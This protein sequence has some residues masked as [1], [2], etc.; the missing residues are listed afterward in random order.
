MKRSRSAFLGLFGLVAGVQ[1]AR[2]GCDPVPPGG[3]TTTPTEQ[4]AIAMPRPGETCADAVAGNGGVWTLE[5]VGAGEQGGAR[6]GRTLDRLCV[7]RWSE[8]KK[9]NPPDIE[10]FPDDRYE[11]ASLERAVVRPLGDA[12]PGLRGIVEK[13]RADLVAQTEAQGTT[14]APPA[15]TVVIGFPDTSREPRAGE[16]ADFIPLGSGPS[17]TPFQGNAHGF[18]LA[19]M[20]RH[21]TCPEGSRGPC[22][23]TPRMSFALPGGTASTRRAFALGI[24]KLVG[25]WVRNEK[26]RGQ[27]LILNLAAGWEPAYECTLRDKPLARRT[28]DMANGQGPSP[29]HGNSDLGPSRTQSWPPEPVPFAAMTSECGGA[30]MVLSIE[31]RAV[32]EELQFA[33]CHGALIVAAAGNDPLVTPERKGPMLPAAWETHG[34]PD[35]ATCARVGAPE[36]AASS[37]D[38]QPLVYAASGVY[39]NDL[40]VV[41][42]RTG[43]TARIVAPASL[44]AAY[45]ADR[46]AAKYRSACATSAGNLCDHT[47]PMTGSSVAATVVSSAAAVL[48]AYNPTWD[49]HRVMDKVHEVGE[50]LGAPSFRLESSGAPDANVAARVSIC[51]AM[52]AALPEKASICAPR[53][54][55]R[56]TTPPSGPYASIAGVFPFDETASLGEVDPQP[57]WPCPACRGYLN[58]GTTAGNWAIT[59]EIPTDAYGALGADLFQVDD[60]PGPTNYPE[61]QVQ[62]TDAGGTSLLV[63][64]AGF[65][66]S[67]TPSPAPGADATWSPTSSRTVN[68][69]FSTPSRTPVAHILVMFQKKRTGGTWLSA[70]QEIPIVTGP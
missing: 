35:A 14:F 30:P 26:G 8:A 52:S 1:Q 13:A 61:R 56:G 68:G 15:K 19:W 59:G 7:Y 11:D 65:T 70:A 2:C 32:L 37:A 60:G 6:A 16:P 42:T 28:A 20:G 43:G 57:G 66:N 49:A 27:P 4:R 3:G 10:A 41:L 17:A 24:R 45:P 67:A 21:L 50:H 51:R 12:E 69:A 44:L 48:W 18:N 38:Y 9:G 54:A 34:T 64:T 33:A 23:T 29:A 62:L 36:P 5:S 55:Y 53:V 22:L 63:G 31:G 39:D 46:D 25:A 40:P 58:P 47:F